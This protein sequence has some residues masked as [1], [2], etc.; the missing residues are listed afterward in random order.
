MVF[1]YT[2]LNKIKNMDLDDEFSGID[3]N[4]ELYRL[5]KMLKDEDNEQLSLDDDNIRYDID[6]DPDETNQY[7]EDGFIITI[8][9]WFNDGTEIKSVDIEG[10]EEKVS[11]IELQDKLAKIISDNKG[12]KIYNIDIN[13][14]RIDNKIK[15]E[16]KIQAHLLGAFL[17]EAVENENY[18]LATQIRDDIKH[19]NGLLDDLLNKFNENVRVG[20]FALTDVIYEEIKR[21]RSK[22]YLYNV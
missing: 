9:K 13:S 16:T 11:E 2:V 18:D 20:E 6:R 7:V 5:L 14:E 8:N 21:L 17:E 22:T 12:S 3:K 4:S 15:R 10:D 1:N 19:R